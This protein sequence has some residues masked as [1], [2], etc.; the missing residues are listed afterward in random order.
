MVAGSVG[1]TGELLAPLGGLTRATAVEIFD[2]QISALVEGGVDVVWIETMS[3]LEELDAALEAASRHDVPVTGTLSFDTAG[4]TMMGVGGADLAVFVASHPGFD[5]VG[6]NCGVGPGDAV[7]A[8]HDVTSVDPSIITIAKPNCGM[9]LYETDRLV[10]P[11]DPDGMA[12]FVDLALRSGVRVIGTCCGSTP[13]H[14]AAIRRAVDA[15][16]GGGRPDRAEV[17]RRLGA[18]AAASAVGR[19]R[20]GRRR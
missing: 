13:E 5:A 11:I 2:E 4:H 7:G 17:E 14:T 20:T 8:C 3:A 15:H 9:P 1:P 10:Y 19:S 6:A 12:D 16:P 18:R